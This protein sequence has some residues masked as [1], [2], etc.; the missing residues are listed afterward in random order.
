MIRAHNAPEAMLRGKVVF[1]GAGEPHLRAHGMKEVPVID[2][3]PDVNYLV[4]RL[5]L[6]IDPE[7]ILKWGRSAR[8][9]VIEHHSIRIAEKNAAL[10]N[11]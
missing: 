11:S 2:A 1:A 3:Q 4:E 10:Y 8:T 9:H 5:S 7:D 6:L